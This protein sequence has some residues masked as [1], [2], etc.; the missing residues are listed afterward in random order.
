MSYITSKLVRHCIVLR[1]SSQDL[2]EIGRFHLHNAIETC[3]EKE[4]R[5]ISSGSKLIDI[6]RQEVAIA[7]ISKIS[8]ERT[9]TP[10][11]FLALMSALDSGKAGL[12]ELDIVANNMH[13]LSILSQD[14]ELAD[15][16]NVVRRE[17]NWRD[18]KIK[19][20]PRDFYVEF[21]KIVKKYCTNT[22]T[23][24]IFPEKPVDAFKSL[25]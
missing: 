21:P 11:K 7:R 24:S 12:V 18:K 1:S 23:T 16:C 4:S 3:A 6:E 2:S 20:R 5:W 13:C 17:G 10:V 15:I 25:R 14:E 22:S 19:F 8:W 9:Y